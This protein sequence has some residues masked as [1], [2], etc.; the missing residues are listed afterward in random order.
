M[1]PRSQPPIQTPSPDLLSISDHLL[2]YLSIYLSTPCDE[3]RARPFLLS[4]S[5]SLYI[6][7]FG[8][9]S[10]GA[11]AEKCSAAFQSCWALRS[12]VPPS[13]HGATATTTTSPAPCGPTTRSARATTP[14]LSRRS[15]RTRARSCTW[16][17]KVAPST[18]RQS[19]MKACCTRLARL[20]YRGPAGCP[21][22]RP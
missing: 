15:A 14:L 16:A 18:T 2:S 21:V 11:F 6:N 8:A 10:E 22:G 13:A 1:H 5:V 17:G 20:R 4:L 12:S 3:R 9:T 7:I 19:C